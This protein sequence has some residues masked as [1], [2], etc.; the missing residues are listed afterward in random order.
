MI[1]GKAEYERAVSLVR[2]VNH[3]ECGTHRLTVENTFVEFFR[4]TSGFD[5]KKF[6]EACRN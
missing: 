6:R 5:E 1:I 2:K 3:A 4:D